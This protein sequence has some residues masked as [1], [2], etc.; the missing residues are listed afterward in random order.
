[1]VYRDDVCIGFMDITPVNPGHLLIVP[2]KHATNL[3]DL[4]PQTGGALFKAAQRSP[5][6]SEN[7]A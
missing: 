2:V 7:P 4:D 3:A 1:V 6:R 5:P